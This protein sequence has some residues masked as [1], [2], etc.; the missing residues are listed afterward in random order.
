MKTKALKIALIVVASIAALVLLIAMSI[1]PI[2]KNYIEKHSPELVGRQVKMKD[3]HL[4]IFKGSLELDSISMYEANGKDVFASIDTFY[5]NL[6]LLKLISKN[7]EIAQLKIIGPYISVIQNG[8]HF[9]FDDLIKKNES[10]TPKD[11]AKSDFPKSIILKDILIRGGKL[12]YDD[13]QLKNIIRMKD[14]GVAIPEI[15]LGNGNTN[16]NLHL[17]LGELASIDSRLKMNMKT[18]AYKLNLKISNLPLNIIKPYLQSSFNIDKCEALMG[19]NLEINGRTDHIMEFSLKGTGNASDLVLTNTS[20]EPLTTASGINIGIKEINYL[21]SSYLFD[22]IRVD[23]ARLDFV[24][25]PGKKPN[26]FLAVF[27]ATKPAKKSATGSANTQ[28]ALSFQVD[29]LDVSDSRFVFTDKTMKPAYILTVTKLDFSSKDFNP[30]KTNTIKLSGN[31]PGNGNF[32]FN[33]TGNSND[34]GNQR[35]MVKLHNFSLKNVSPYCRLYTA[36]D[37]TNGVVNFDSKTVIRNNNLVSKNGVDVYK[38][39]ASKKHKELKPEY[40]VPLRL[41]LYILKDKDDK[42]KFDLPVQGNIHDPKFSYSKIVFKTLVNLMVKVGEAPFKFLAGALGFGSSQPESIDIDP[43]QN[44]FTAEQYS[45]LNDMAEIIRKKPEMQFDFTQLAD[46]KEE[47][48][49]FALYKTK[50]NYLSMHMNEDNKATLSEADIQALKE[51]DNAFRSYVDSALIKSGKDFAD[52]NIK[53]KVMMMYTPDSLENE[54]MTTLRHRDAELTQYMKNTYN[55]TD[56][57]LIIHTAAKDSLK[58]Y[59]SNSCYH[60]GMKMAGGND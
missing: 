30:D 52:K 55:I 16:G 14:L 6:E 20:H 5:V 39:E 26:N 17:R 28:P 24:M 45:K 32:Q 29:D 54:F 53:E 37:L 19:A 49:E 38:A 59:A 25:N 12:V 57:S 10:Q 48:E 9:N 36:Y 2:A 35:I 46:I 60:I 58:H 40:K 4:N 51:N 22:Y 41:A 1:S 47:M 23:D 13:Q 11:T 44:G 3:L 43:L 33:W 42:I 18:N 21:K 8:D 27:K 15:Q 31:F 56:K 50:Y 7:V 34:L